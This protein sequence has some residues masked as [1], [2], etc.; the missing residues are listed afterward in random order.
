MV[1]LINHTSNAIFRKN[2]IRRVFPNPVTFA[3]DCYKNKQ[4]EAPGKSTGIG[5]SLSR[6]GN[7][8]TDLLK[9]VPDKELEQLLVQ[10]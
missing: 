3:R 1:G 2:P 5:T 6:T 7:L 10:R 4:K 8:A 9:E